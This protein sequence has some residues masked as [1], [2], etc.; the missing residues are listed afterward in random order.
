[1]ARDGSMLALSS[2]VRQRRADRRLAYRIDPGMA[3]TERLCDPKRWH[4]EH[5]PT[6]AV[7]V[8]ELLTLEND[9]PPS[10][11]RRV[12][13]P[14]FDDDALPIPPIWPAPDP[15]GWSI[16]NQQLGANQ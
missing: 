2:V 3:L 4:A 13:V 11:A 6:E 14:I 10:R 9:P 16:P 1:M 12:T 7:P 5:A 8:V 15:A